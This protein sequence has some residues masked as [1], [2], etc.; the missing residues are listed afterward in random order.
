MGE[1]VPLCQVD[2]RS[3]AVRARSAGPGW[4]AASAMWHAA[5]ALF[6]TQQG[7]EKLAQRNLRH[8]DGM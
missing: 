3:K 2:R 1:G 4:Q 7:L 6:S 5:C 8:G